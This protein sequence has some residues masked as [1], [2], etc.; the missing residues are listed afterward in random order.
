MFEGVIVWGIVYSGAHSSSQEESSPGRRPHGRPAMPALQGANR[1]PKCE[2][3]SAEY[4]HREAGHWGES[5]TGGGDQL[6]PQDALAW[7]IVVQGACHSTKTRLGNHSYVEVSRVQVHRI[8]LGIQPFVKL[9]CNIKRWRRL[10]NVR[11]ENLEAI[12]FAALFCRLLSHR[13]VYMEC[14]F[15][16]CICR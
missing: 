9:L 16:I 2:H 7:G 12:T 11:Y 4:H 1:C 5:T 13:L 15:C 10:K 6:V 3:H 14:Q 8:I